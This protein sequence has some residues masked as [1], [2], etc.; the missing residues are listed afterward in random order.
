MSGPYLGDTYG[1]VRF[2]TEGERVIG[3]ATGGPC[4][5]EPDTEVIS[6]ELQGNVLVAHVLL[7]QQG[8]S[9]CEERKL[10][11]ALV[12]FNP[13]DRVLSA[14][15]RLREGC[16]SPALKGNALV[17]TSTAPQDDGDVEPEPESEAAKP[18]A[19]GAMAPPAEGVGSAALVAQ[20]RRREPEIPPLEEGQRQLLAGNHAAAQTLFTHVLESDARNPE[21]LM[22]LGASQLGRGDTDGALKTLE[23][24]RASTRP[25]VHLWLAYAHF[26]DGNRGRARESLRKALDLGWAPGNRPLEAVPESA[27]RGEIEILMQ[28]RARKRASGRDSTGS[29]STSP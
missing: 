17:L 12:V 19:G 22:G 27:L 15:I 3:T 20:A 13:K 10:H 11:P 28:Q 9:A 23:R 4:R 6:G 29:G 2:R 18:P 16:S 14:M 25:D 7:C 1:Q 24:A 26:R 5:F 21:A 8:G